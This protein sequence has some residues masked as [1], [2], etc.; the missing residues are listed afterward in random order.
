MTGVDLDRRTFRWWYAGLLGATLVFRV[1]Y[2]VGAK[3][4]DLPDGDQVYYSAQAVAIANG[5]WFAAPFALD[6]YA[7]DHA[8][9]TAL[10]VAPVSWSDGHALFWQR[11]VMAL[12]GVAVVAVIGVLARWLFGRSIALVA[13]ATAMLYANL[14][15]NDGLVMAETLAALCVAAVLLAAYMFDLRR[16]RSLAVWMGVGVGFAGLARAELLLLGPLLVLPL[17]L[18]DRGVAVRTRL[19]HLALATAAAVCVVAPWVIRNQ[20]RFEHPTFM[21]T[22]DGQTLLGANCGPSYGDDARGFWSYDCV[23]SLPIPADADQSERSTIMRDTA[24]EYI[25]DHLDQ[26]PSVLLARLGRGLSVWRFEEMSSFNTAEGR[27]RWASTIGVVQFWFLAP[28]AAFGVWRWPSRQPRWPA[29]VCVAISLLTILAFYGIPRFRIAAE[30]VV[31]LGAAV[32]MVAVWSW[33]RREPMPG[34]RDQ[35][36]APKTL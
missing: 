16:T 13:M 23:V 29:L 3:R 27:E 10:V 5:R 8:P 33:L 19:L 9:L 30:V 1:A 6:T 4:N 25:G 15:M 2:V 26:V 14:W 32:G 21:S 7:A 34:R 17:T 20:I 35:G 36:I 22:Q 12:F 24:I 18:V 11:M 31:V 28:L